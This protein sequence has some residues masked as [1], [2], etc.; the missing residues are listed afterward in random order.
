MNN[1]DILLIDLFVIGDYILVCVFSG[2]FDYDCL[3]NCKFYF[4]RLEIFFDFLM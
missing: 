3:L 4:V 2:L 1:C